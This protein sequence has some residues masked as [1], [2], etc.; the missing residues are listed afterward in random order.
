MG[1]DSVASIHTT[2]T[3]EWF[4]ENPE[5]VGSPDLNQIC[6][7]SL[8]FLDLFPIY[9]EQSK[10][11]RNKNLLVVADWFILGRMNQSQMS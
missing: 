1:L 7:P 2:I 5:K 9:C 4:I 3:K 10:Q 8:P 6:T 11:F